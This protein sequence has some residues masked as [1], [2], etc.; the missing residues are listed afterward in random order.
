MIEIIEP[1]EVLAVASGT[2]RVGVGQESF[3]SVEFLA[4]L[5]RRTAG[6]NC[7]CSRATLR[8][9]LEECLQG[10]FDDEQDL[11]SR[12]ES[13]I[14]G[15]IV[16]G[17]LLE[18]DDVSTDDSGVASTWVFAA[19]PSFVLRPSGSAYLLGIVPDQDVFLPDPLTARTTTSGFTRLVT[20]ELGEDLR[21]I[22]RGLGLNELS[23]DVWLKSPKAIEPGEYLKLMEGRLRRQGRSGSINELEVIGHNSSV[24][25]YRG[26]WRAPGKLSGTHVGRRPQMY[27]A[28][29]W[30]LVALSEG[31][32]QLLL[33]L[34]LPRSRWRGCDEAW[35]L[36][37][38]Y[39]HCQ[40]NPQVFRTSQHDTNIRIDFFSPIPQ[41]A[42]RR[43][44]VFGRACRSEKCLFFY[45][46][47]GAEA[48]N[49]LEF[50]QNVVWLVPVSNADEVS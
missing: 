26:R 44:M 47:P 25:Y 43:L 18:L 6:I 33:D 28:P 10:L 21:E 50:L 38:A 49:E 37:L 2:L 7:P 20:P 48:E 5:L 16:A 9:S 19:P 31:E 1:S 39:D 35:R 17:D 14:Q 3:L 12:I 24:K 42:E 34:P 27:G 45:L 13:A 8:A 30:C 11:T 23:A 22:L 36:Q 41:W 40:R 4:A 32:P 29:L 46:L 15:L